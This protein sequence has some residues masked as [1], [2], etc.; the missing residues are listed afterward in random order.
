MIKLLFLYILE[1]IKYYLGCYI[2]Y[3]NRIKRYWIPSVGFV[4]YIIF[5]L[6]ASFQEPGKN[7]VIQCVFVLIALIM[8]II[9]RWQEKIGHAIV[10]CFFITCMDES[11]GM[12]YKMAKI[13]ML[14]TEKA[15]YAE[16]FLQ[17]MGTLCVLLTVALLKQRMRNGK[18]IWDFIRNNIQY[19][20]V[21]VAAEMLF[22]I[23]GL[24]YLSSNIENLGG[25]RIIII[26]CAA[27]YVSLGVLVAFAVYVGKT[28]AEMEQLVKNENFLKN[29][30]KHY[31]ETLLEKEQDTR[32]YRH[33]MKNHLVCLEALARAGNNEALCSY[34]QEMQE[35]MLQIQKKMHV[36]GNQIIDAITSYYCSFL[37]DDI[38]VQIDGILDVDLDEMQLCTIYANLLQNAVEEV[39]QSKDTTEQFVKIQMEQGKEFAK[40]CISN[41]LSKEQYTREN[42]DFFRTKKAD[43]KNH[44]LG[45]KNVKRALEE[46]GGKLELQKKENQFVV[47][48]CIPVHSNH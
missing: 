16:H 19:A 1:V 8:A 26:L 11:I 15:W 12:L 25:R 9:G 34:V 30:Q 36:T 40:I 13:G 38:C 41:S 45:L 21:L 29:M 39:L 14:N 24:S 44:G 43:K 6:I 17:S 27:A 3:G 10:L 32:D 20:V 28:N 31:Y 4:G 47:M 7:Y 2:C 18:K 46:I 37:S 33:D 23:A 5:L 22:T 48:A 42:Q 35:K